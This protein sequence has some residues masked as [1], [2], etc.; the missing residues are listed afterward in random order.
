MLVLPLLMASVKPQV[1]LTFRWAHR[2]V[3]EMEPQAFATLEFLKPPPEFECWPALEPSSFPSSES[4]G[5]PWD[6]RM[7]QS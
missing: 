3:M 5:L 1:G 4:G 6:C 7:K 2:L